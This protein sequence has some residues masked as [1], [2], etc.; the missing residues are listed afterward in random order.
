MPTMSSALKRAL[1][2]AIIALACAPLLAVGAY[3]HTE[4]RASDPADGDIAETLDQVTLEFSSA[5]LAIGVE[6][7]LVDGAGDVH[8]LTPEVDEAGIVT[9]PVDG[10]VAGA[11]EVRWRVVAEDGH[12]IEGVIEFEFVPL[13]PPPDPVPSDPVP[14][15]S[16]EPSLTPT[17]VDTPSVTSTPSPSPT[18]TAVE[19]VM[20]EAQDVPWWA[21]AGVGLGVVAAIVTAIVIA[22][23]R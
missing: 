23:R 15:L 14:T 17:P 7:T 5:I 6:L 11:I 8:E 3:A 22:R 4:L 2:A 13:E 1:P 10:A 9:S 12:P 19:Q 21:I 18:T 16:S 20:P